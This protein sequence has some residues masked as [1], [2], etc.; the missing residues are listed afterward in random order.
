MTDGTP[1]GI[2]TVSSTKFAEATRGF[3]TAVAVASSHIPGKTAFVGLGVARGVGAE[4]GAKVV[5]GAW[6]PVGAVVGMPV[7]P[8]VVTLWHRGGIESVSP[9]YRPAPAENDSFEGPSSRSPRAEAPAAEE[10]SS[11]GSC[12]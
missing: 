4:L 2:Q 8:F 1:R 7:K 11:S 6:E 12:P 5:V 3:S 9:R 10:T